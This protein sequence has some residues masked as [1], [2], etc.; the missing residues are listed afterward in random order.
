MILAAKRP[1]S[2]AEMNVAVHA[3]SASSY[4]DMDLEDDEDFRKTLRNWCGLF[5][6]IYDG[7]VEFLHQ[8]AREF[9]LRKP[10]ETPGQYCRWQGSM[11]IAQAH[12]TIAESCVAYLNFPDHDIEVPGDELSRTIATWA[13]DLAGTRPYFH[14]SACFWPLHFRLAQSP[15]GAV[16]IPSVLRLC[17][18]SEER[19]SEIWLL[20]YRWWQGNGPWRLREHCSKLHLASYLGLNKIVEVLLQ[21]S[22]DANAVDNL[23]DTPL[24]LAAENGDNRVINLLISHGADPNKANDKGDTALV[25]AAKYGYTEVAKLL[26]DNGVD[27]N[28]T[29]NEGNTAL[30]EAAYFNHVHIVK[31]LL[32][33]SADPNIANSEG[34]T[35][36]LKAAIHCRIEVIELLL[37]SGADPSKSNDKGQT[38]LSWAAERGSVN[39]AKL[40]LDAGA[41]PHGN[42]IRPMHS[43]IISHRVDIV[44]LLLDSGLDVND[45]D[46][47]G[48]TSLHYA[49]NR[50]KVEIVNILMERG[51]DVNAVNDYGETPLHCAAS[52]Q[53]QPGVIRLLVEH[54]ARPNVRDQYGETPLH[55]S[56][57]EGYEENA[58]LLLGLGADP[59]ITDNKGRTPRALAVEYKEKKGYPGVLSD[60]LVSLFDENRLPE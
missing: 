22:M 34:G 17:A 1:L 31:M 15:E 18:A 12:A 46:S 39:I 14:Y 43:A 9:L 27:P 29:N 49:A 28:K 8:T 41:S 58:R 38:A 53:D 19:K 20:V 35:A 37:D 47:K 11:S 25:K 59:E 57:A 50:G 33:N 40:L 5:V 52:W 56:I 51:A 2:L 10:S 13:F 6:K 23:G 60:W 16:L 44:R 21:E 24:T 7:K 55:R 54:G 26:L 36:L 48:Y 30:S 4:Y 42:N 45:R 32:D 3:H